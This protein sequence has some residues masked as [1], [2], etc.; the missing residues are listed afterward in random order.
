M[1]RKLNAT[2]RAAESAQPGHPTLDSARV[3]DPMLRR[4]TPQT[5]L[6]REYAD[7]TVDAVQ[8]ASPAVAP[9]VVGVL[10]ESF[11]L[12]KGDP[13]PLLLIGLIAGS[14]GAGAQAVSLIW[15]PNQLT[16]TDVYTLSPSMLQSRLSATPVPVL[17]VL[18]LIGWVVAGWHSTTLIAML[19][20][21]RQGTVMTV[22]EALRIGWQRL[23]AALGAWLGG[24]ALAALIL[25]GFLLAAYVAFSILTALLPPPGPVRLVLGGIA[26][27]AVAITF[28]CLAFV[29]IGKLLLLAP[30]VVAEDADWW[31]AMAQVHDLAIGSLR[32]IALVAAAMQL[33][34]FVGFW[35]VDTL[36]AP[37]LSRTS[38]GALLF[39]LAVSSL[40]FPV[41]WSIGVAL[42]GRLSSRRD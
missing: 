33:A 36:Y 31:T 6:P 23:P 4:A 14:V 13:W 26:I 39:G 28:L 22:R 37:V 18:A 21:R 5:G 40:W 10:A 27:L 3:I 15:Y 30:V 34:N 20:A 16:A 9:R 1:R 2:K 41:Q 12:I 38:A 7:V 35:L 19:L 17:I 32:R 29:R 11:H 42:Y 8:P 24:L 25:G